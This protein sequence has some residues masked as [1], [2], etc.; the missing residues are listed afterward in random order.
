MMTSHHGSWPKADRSSAPSASAAAS[1]GA[2]RVAPVDGDAGCPATPRSAST[3]RPKEL[4]GTHTTSSAHGR[5]TSTGSV[6][7][8]AVAGERDRSRAEPASA[9]VG[10]DPGDGTAGGGAA[11][12]VAV[13]QPAVVEQLLPGGEADAVGAGVERRLRPARRSVARSPSHGPISSIS[14]RTSATVRKPSGARRSSSAMPARTRRSGSEAG[15]C[16]TASNG[17]GRPSQLTNVPALSVTGA[18][19]KH[20]VGDAGHL[21]LAQLEADHERRR[22]RAPRGPR[23]GRRCRRG[24]RRRRPG[25]R[26]R[27]RRSAATIASASRPARL[28]QRVDA[29]GGGRRRRGPRRRRPD[30]RRAAGWAGSRPRPRRGRRRG[31]APRPAGRRCVGRGR[32]RRVSAPGDGGEPLADQDHGAGVE[33]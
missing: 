20:H 3:P 18:T 9:S 27:R 1:S 2:S 6:D 11:G 5:A 24:R 14:A 16:S 7:R 28:G 17:R 30:G 22:P 8:A 23:R 13:L 19:G 31:A 12:C 29:P 4:A 15:L 26:A 25:R 32:R 21:G 10:G 33:P